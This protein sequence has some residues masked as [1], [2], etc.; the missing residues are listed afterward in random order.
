MTGDI[1]LSSTL[2][3]LGDV[4]LA[5]FETASG[6]IHSREEWQIPQGYIPPRSRVAR[7]LE[8]E[9]KKE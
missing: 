2:D 3:D 6:A 1:P 4:F 7:G 5:K 9:A 8:A